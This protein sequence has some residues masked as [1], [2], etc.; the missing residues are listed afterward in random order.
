MSFKT[1]VVRNNNWVLLKCR[2]YI[3]TFDWRHPFLSANTLKKNTNMANPI[4]L[5]KILAYYNT[6]PF[7]K[8]EDWVEL[9]K[10]F[11]ITE[12]DLKRVVGKTLEDYFFVMV[13]CYSNVESTVV[14]NEAL[15]KLTDTPSPDGLILFKNHEK[16]LVEVKSTTES[17]WS[18]SKNRLQKQKGFA[19]KMGID[20]RFAIFLNGYWGVYDYDFIESKKF[21]IEHPQDLR[22]SL[23]DSLFDPLLVKIPKGLKI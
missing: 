10:K 1:G 18:Y 8:D 3:L 2:E 11:Y 22:F 7:L 17:S 4:S 21:K 15:S 13:Q 12:A 19:E 16:L 5:E 6:K 14:F 23:F 9:G 20:L